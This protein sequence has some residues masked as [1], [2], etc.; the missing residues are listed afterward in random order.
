MTAF[1]TALAMIF[2][3]PHMAV[4]AEWLP[5]GASPGTMI[6]AVRKAPDQLT[7]YGEARLWSE[8]LQIDVLVAAVPKPV[9]GDRIVIA[10]EVF[11]VQGE[12]LRDRE[13]LLWTLALVPV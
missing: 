7:N 11:E 8:T 1:A 6:R 9:S 10:G 5:G 4:D 3:D 2:A 13:R 12:P